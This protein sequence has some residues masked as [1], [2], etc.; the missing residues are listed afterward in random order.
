MCQGLW[1]K[2]DHARYQQKNYYYVQTVGHGA[3]VV[4]VHGWGMHAGIWQD[5]VEGLAGHYRV[6][7]LDLPGHGYSRTLENQ[8]GLVQ[9]ADMVA[10]AV[11][12]PATW[13]GWS[14]G[15]LVAQQVA[16]SAPEHISRL[17]LVSSTPS[18]I[19]RTG[20]LHGIDLPV[21]QRFAE[22]LQ[23]DYRAVLKRF[24][25]LEVH[26]STHANE[27]L[28]LLKAM[29]FQH[30]EPEI[31][32]LKAGLSILETS[33][34]RAELPRI[35][36]PALLLMGQRDQLIPAAAGVAMCAALPDARLHVVAGAGHAPFFSHLPEFMAELRAFLD[37]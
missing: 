35:G 12:A 17:V 3:D 4:L 29:L 7:V 1:S 28:R 13:I 25:A 32:A 15:G 18:F 10:A 19:K 36:C 20:W 30:G 24:I 31:S 8:Y 14:L 11:P 2:P 16:L 23:Q 9:L 6:T 33:D 27:Q 21:L 26:G 22:E 37:V 34:L 5:V